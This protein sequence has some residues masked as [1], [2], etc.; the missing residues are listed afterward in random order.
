MKPVKLTMCAF[1]PYAGKVEVSLAD[2]GD[3]GLYLIT[4]DTG[5]GK[6]T[7][8]DAITFALYGEASGT[9]R[10]SSMLRSDFAA[11]D[12]KTFVE[13]EFLYRDRLYKVERN[14]KYE[15][16][17]K[18]G[19]GTT[20]ENANA[21]L[22][23][24]DGSVKTGSTAVAEAIKELIGIDKN[25]FSQIAMIAQGDFLKLLLASTDERGK[26][27]RKIFNTSIYQQFQNE[28]KNQAN[29]LK[30]QYEDLRKSVLQYAGEVS[31]N[32]GHSAYL[33]LKDIKK[34]NNIHSLE[35]LL[36]CLGVLIEE[37]TKAEA[38][39]KLAGENLQ[40]R[41]AKLT[42]EIATAASNNTRLDKLAKSQERLSALEE[43]QKEYEDKSSKLIS[44]QS[45]LFHVKPIADE[46]E[47]AKKLYAELKDGIEH[48]NAT[49]C[50]KAPELEKLD[51]L[52]QAEKNKDPE[53]EAISGE[54]T[55]AEHGLLVYEE[56]EELQK[57]TDITAKSLEKIIVAIKLKQSQKEKLENEKEKL[58]KELIDLIDVG[59]EAERAKKQEEDAKN[60]VAKLVQLKRDLLL[61]EK[62]NVALASAQSKYIKA[63]SE[64]TAKT[65]EYEKLEKAF[66]DEQAG[67]MASKLLE[68]QPCPVCGSTIHPDLAVMAVDAPTEMEL[69]QA[70]EDADNARE[71]AQQCSENANTIK[72][73]LETAKEAFIT[74][75]QPLLGSTVFADIPILLGT[76]TEKAKANMEKCSETLGDLD[77]KINRKKECEKKI[78]EIEPVIKQMADKILDL[79]NEAGNLRITQG[80]F[81]A[82]ITNIKSKLAFAGR[83][84]AEADIELKRK[85]LSI[86]KSALASAEKKFIDCKS[87]ISSANAVLLDL[88]GRLETAKTDLRT[89]QN[90]FTT[91]LRERDFADQEHFKRLLMNE[92]EIKVLKYDVD[93]YYDQLKETR[94]DI[95]TL[96]EETK[97]T[98][99]VDIAANQKKK[100]DLV[101]EKNKSEEKRLAVYSRLDTNKRLQ[102]T[103][104]SKQSEM[105]AIEEK[106]LCMR[107]LSD[108]ANGDLSGKQKLAFEQFVQATYFNQI[109][110]EANKR[111]SYMTQGRFELVRKVD[112]GN[113]RSQ[114]GL[115]LDV[116]DNYTGK[117]RSV[118]TLSGGESFKASLSMALGLSDMIQSYAGGIQLDTIFVDEGFGALDSESLSQA[119]AVLG[120]LTSG[121]RMVG[122]ISHVS[123]LKEH[124]D[125][126]LVVKKN[127]CG[128]EI[129]LVI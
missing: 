36:A 25:Q 120:D 17:K 103:I 77:A 74:L 39:E 82:Q 56:L 126:Q 115:E 114:T 18:S 95:L 87:D 125:K 29:S 30:G 48:Q 116:I 70:K 76:E 91:V 110:A 108:T 38:D 61:L 118:K 6:T 66:L 19:E 67:I 122:I 69:K 28:L 72:V 57:N 128:S 65:S 104:E 64:S 23:W 49:L 21:T 53:R 8:F 51:E 63:Q 13:L 84:E 16:A 129:S 97:D 100:I 34:S 33:E 109:I 9:N 37:D 55:S 45:A 92:E 99:Y 14:P 124:I 10:D 60:L 24:P 88:S 107:N 5:A 26:I 111:F 2:F 35:K 22:T 7:I 113:L 117:S 80:S 101:G 83:E 1:G 41:I 71:K 73:K 52:Y 89:V 90:K 32:E 47:R 119:I 121:N 78:A 96:S 20:T 54:I 106:Y 98:E 46:I 127:V 15:R 86:M 112:P 27:F 93:Y 40:D 12:V 3:S 102:N 85:K 94:A 68:G 59:V 79:E 105:K 31:C 58:K 42:A 123:E 62:D 4:G 44:A 50:A 11:P 81:A 75:A 43:R